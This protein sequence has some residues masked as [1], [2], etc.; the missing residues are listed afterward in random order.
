MTEYC[1]TT[2]YVKQ[3]EP[4]TAPSLDL[5]CQDL[6]TFIN[7]LSDQT[8]TENRLSSSSGVCVRKHCVPCLMALH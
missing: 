8:P 4:V 7:E 3:H 6:D 1:E 5:L 2:S